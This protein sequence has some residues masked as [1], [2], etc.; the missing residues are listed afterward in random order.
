M[1]T[2]MAV[3]SVM[4]ISAPEQLIKVAF[5]SLDGDC[6]DQ[7]FGS[8]QG[9]YV[10]GVD[11]ESS[12]LLA[13]KHFQ[14]ENQD[15]NEDKLKPKLKWLAG[16]DL[17]YCGS[18]GGSATRQLVSLG[19]HPIKVKEGPDIEELIEELQSDIKTGQSPLI[20]RIIVNKSSK[21]ED[22]FDDMAEDDWEE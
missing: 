16:C 7:H 8:A 17:V 18:I 19:V 21:N 20:Q 10:Y 4:D 5:A 13:E 22:R 3:E 6:V 15:G 1:T 11:K 14:K 9:F 2:T 12:A